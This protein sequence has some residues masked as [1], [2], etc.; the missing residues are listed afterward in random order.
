MS[1]ALLF[2]LVTLL[3]TLQAGT[4]S[5]PHPQALG[6]YNFT[7]YVLHLFWLNNKTIIEYGFRINWRI[8]EIS[9][10]VI[11]LFLEAL[12]Y[13]TFLDLRRSSD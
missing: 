11:R 4:T 6:H 5:S 10:G 13:N 9:D 1:K 3:V 12:A 8:M 7:M 2:C